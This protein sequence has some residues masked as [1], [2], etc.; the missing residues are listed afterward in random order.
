MIGA[1]PGAAIAA[2]VVASTWIAVVQ[3]E[4]VQPEL[5]STGGTMLNAWADYDGDG[6]P[7]LFIGF[8]GAANA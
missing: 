6:D 2:A 7:D 1:M 5:L 4:P 8:N 3:F